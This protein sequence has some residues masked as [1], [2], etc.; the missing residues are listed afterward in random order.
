MHFLMR[1][2]LKKRIYNDI[3]VFLFIVISVL[4]NEL[5]AE[6][7]VFNNILIEGNNRIATDTIIE[8]ANVSVGLPYTDQ[9]INNI[10]QK[11]NSSKFFKSV[12]IV[13]NNNTLKILVVERPII[14]NIYFEGNKLIKNETLENIITSKNRNTLFKSQIESD[15]EKIASSYLNKGRLFAT[16]TPKIIERINN[17]VDIVFEIFEGQIVEIEKI[18]FIGNRIFSNQRLKSVIASKQAGLFS[19]FFSSDT[20]IEDRIEYDKQLL[21]NFYVGKG[22]ID[23]NILSTSVETTRNNDA[24]FLNYNIREG[25]QYKFGNISFYSNIPYVD[26]DKIKTLNLIN[27]NEI[28]NSK[29]IDELIDKIE[30]YLADAN[31]NFINV[32]PEFI[33]KNDVYLVNININLVEAEKVFVERINIQGNST[34][35]DEVIRLN[36][37]FAEGDPFNIRGIQ[38]AADKI[39]STGFFKDVNISTRNG[40]DKGLIIVDVDLVEQATGSFGIGAGFNSSDGATFNLNIDERNFLGRGQKLGFKFSNSKLERNISFGI[41]DNTF[42]GRN[43]FSGISLGMITS[44]PGTSSIINNKTFINP[45]IGFPLS[46]NS[47]LKISYNLSS[48]NMKKYSDSLIIS[49][50]IEKDLGKFNQSG[51]IFTYDVN[52]TNYISKPTNGYKVKF[53]QEIN[54]LGG[55]SSF[56]KS[57]ISFDNYNSLLDENIILSSKLKA[58]II[59]GD[60]AKFIN[61]FNL[62][63]D[64]LLGF[65]NN[66]IG[67]IDN[68]FD[69]SNSDYLG[70]N[71]F[72]SLNLEASFPIGFPD[73]YGIFGGVFLSSGSVWGLDDTD[74]G[75]IDDSFN[76]RVSS[77]VSLFWDTLIGP[78]RFNF[79]RP[80]KKIDTDVEENFRFTVDTRF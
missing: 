42:L 62:G 19:N 40:S 59:L 39:R 9:K 38:K 24:F 17:R 69:S 52:K 77:G 37:D 58:G 33:R 44:K 16:V 11:L 22:Y 34:T 32:D 48:N 26:I 29:R 25:Q 35:Q 70:G 36:F 80:I 41:E 12:R 15:A 20:Y 14:Q 28:Y 2:K 43:L 31:I 78:L 4:P 75:R 23:F 13:S 74:N 47:F 57:T 79:S 46:K 30:K 72:T 21:R 66:G 51:I 8:I 7:K 50:I 63:G 53:I 73:E 3:I 54:G 49:P 5:F 68:T 65:Q 6:E 56:L 76:L 10:L 55:D 67:P 64:T 61:R 18:S 45:S 71:M 60:E 1:P 27:K